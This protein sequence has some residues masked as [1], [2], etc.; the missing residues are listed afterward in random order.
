MPYCRFTWFRLFA[1]VYFRYITTYYCW[2]PFIITIIGASCYVY[3]FSS[4][5]YFIT[6]YISL[7]FS[8]SALDDELSFTYFHYIAF[9]F[10][11]F[12]FAG[13][14]HST[15]DFMP[16]RL[17]FFFISFRWPSPTRYATPIG[18]WLTLRLVAAC[19]R[20]A[21]A[22]VF[23]PPCHAAFALAGFHLFLLFLFSCFLPFITPLSFFIYMLL[24]PFFYISR[25]DI[26]ALLLCFLMPFDYFLS[27]HW[28]YQS[29]YY[30]D[31]LHSILFVY[32]IFPLFSPSFPSSLFIRAL[33]I[34]A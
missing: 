13:F 15:A 30:I 31:I 33:F 27:S 9:F 32:A 23:L 19:F 14:L 4:L 18:H 16:L 12:P 17:I 8:S 22:I 5:I 25:Y 7:S 34:E 20:H 2:E 24:I 29:L 28:H 1:S 6:A 3:A 11:C 26:S 21:T 10:A